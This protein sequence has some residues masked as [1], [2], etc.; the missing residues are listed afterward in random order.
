MLL[1]IVAVVDE[2]D[3]VTVSLSIITIVWRRNISFRRSL[4]VNMIRR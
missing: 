1:P 3:L 4:H 2:I